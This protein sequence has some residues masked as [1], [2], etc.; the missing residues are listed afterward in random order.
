MGKPAS[1]PPHPVDV[2]V[3]SRLRAERMAKGWSQTDLAQALGL[4]FQ[5][6][7]KYEKGA[8]RISASVVV[9][10]CEALGIELADL[11]PPIK[12]A[13]PEALGVQIDAYPGGAE[14]ADH[15]VKMSTPHRRL[16]L[17]TAAAFRAVET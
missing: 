5:Q 17:A 4:S 2:Y 11:F 15:Y 1:I 7:Q 14:L 9:T 8:N 16:L 13:G 6:V 3:G 12:R 10:A